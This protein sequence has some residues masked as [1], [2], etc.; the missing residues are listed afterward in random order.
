[1]PAGEVVDILTAV[2][3]DPAAPASC[4]PGTFASVEDGIVR[5]TACSAGSYAFNPSS[6]ACKPC[7][8]GRVAPYLGSTACRTCQPGTYSSADGKACVACPA[9]EQLLGAGLAVGMVR[10]IRCL[11]HSLPLPLMPPDCMLPNR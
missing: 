9:G 1:M 8:A 6:A 11:S 4:L 2:L 5:C 10:S 7:P 3:R